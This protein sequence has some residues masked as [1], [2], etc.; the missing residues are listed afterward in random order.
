M[1]RAILDRL[2]ALLCA[3]AVFAQLPS[4][5][6]SSLRS[7]T[8]P[9]GC[10]STGIRMRVLGKTTLER[11]IT[12]AYILV[13]SRAPLTILMIVMSDRIECAQ[14]LGPFIKSPRQSCTP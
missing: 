12:L 3:S 8:K 6:A 14:C 1:A 10:R 11:S 13:A 7:N 2:T 5:A 9:R 4:L